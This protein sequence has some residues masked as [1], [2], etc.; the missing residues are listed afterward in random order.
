MQLKS[1]ADVELAINAICFQATGFAAVAGTST[2]DE[3]MAACAGVAAMHASIEAI[4]IGTLI[5]LAMQLIPIIFGE[6]GFTLDKL[7]AVL[8]L[9]KSIFAT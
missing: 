6:G 4:P 1:A 3:V 8:E 2:T 5:A 7:M 9:I